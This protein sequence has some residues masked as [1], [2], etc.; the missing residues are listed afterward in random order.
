[1]DNSSFDISES[2]IPSGSDVA[3]SAQT[4]SGDHSVE[5]E[6]DLSK[7]PPASPKA[8]G[9]P[10]RDANDLVRLAT[11]Q[12][13]KAVEV[14]AK[15]R[16][17]DLAGEISE[18]TLDKSQHVFDGLRLHSLSNLIQALRDERGL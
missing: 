12:I 14:L 18:Q 10:S 8:S 16:E 9:E 7:E 3:A 6:M 2:I 11:Q 17:S 13:V 1:M 5:F 15:V 4:S